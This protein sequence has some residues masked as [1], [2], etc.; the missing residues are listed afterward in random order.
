MAGWADP[1][2][3]KNPEITLK[4]M[5]GTASCQWADATRY[6]AATLK[7]VLYL[8]W[9]QSLADNDLRKIRHVCEVAGVDVA[10]RM[11]G[12]DVAAQSSCLGGAIVG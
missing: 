1:D 2:P 3:I 9:Q 12:E 5:L 11:L 7:R 4:Q 6:A 10:L 8:D